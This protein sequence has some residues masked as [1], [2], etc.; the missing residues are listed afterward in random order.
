MHATWNFVSKRSYPSLA[1]FFLTAVSAALVMAPALYTYRHSVAHIATPVWILI[2]ATGLAQ[3]IYFF[4]LAGAYRAGDISLAYPLARALPVLFIAAISLLLRGGGAIGRWGLVGM[5]MITAGC[6]ILPLPHFR[7]L[8]PG[9]YA[10]I[11]TLMALVAAV[12]TTAYTLIDDQALRHLRSSPTVQLSTVEITLLFISLQTISTA[13]ML[14][15]AAVLIKGEREQFRRLLNSRRVPVTALV[16]GVVIMATYGL[17][18]AAMA[19]VTNV[20]YVAAFRQLSI[21]IGALLG[22]ILAREPRFRP[23]L[24]GIG[25]VMIGLLLVGIG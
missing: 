23:K 15:L 11:V 13:V 4:G 5:V 18:L 14:G 22:L 7:R 3:A 6:I 17:V 8:R 20:S 9:H 10:N 25:I 19:Y 12:G 16:T 24:I 1:F 2:V 21:P